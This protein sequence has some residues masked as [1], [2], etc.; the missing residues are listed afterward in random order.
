MVVV[1]GKERGGRLAV[2]AGPARLE[3]NRGRRVVGGVGDNDGPPALGRGTGG[4]FEGSQP[5]ADHQL[6]RGVDQG[7]EERV[8]EREH[9]VGEHKEDVKVGNELVAARALVVGDNDRVDKGV[10]HA[11][12]LDGEGQVGV[13]DPGPGLGVGPVV[14]VHPEPNEVVGDPGGV[15]VAQQRGHERRRKR[16]E[17]EGAQAVRVDLEHVGQD[18]S[19]R[20]RGDQDRAR[21]DPVRDL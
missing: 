1:V 19:A 18:P 4:V 7:P 3:R 13:G 14:V 2:G 16:R 15:K 8:R 10:V 5:G 20:D 12:A 6:G 11:R 9:H 21:V 17:T